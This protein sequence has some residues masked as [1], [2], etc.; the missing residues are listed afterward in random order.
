MNMYGCILYYGIG[1]NTSHRR[2][3]GRVRGGRGEGGGRG[4]E[5]E[6]PLQKRKRQKMRGF[7][8]A[9]DLNLQPPRCL[10]LIYDD[11]GKNNSGGRAVTGIHQSESTWVRSQGWDTVDGFVFIDKSTF[12]QHYQSFQPWLIPSS[13]FITSSQGLREVGAA[14]HRS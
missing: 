5:R 10:F 2:T 6:T 8:A 13:S 12:L 4:P 14:N 7:S 3:S 11:D 1:L 9:I